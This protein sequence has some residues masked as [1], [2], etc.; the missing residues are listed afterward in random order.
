MC[1]ISY[2]V[3]KVRASKKQT[4]TNNNH[5]KCRTD[6]S[7]KPTKYKSAVSQSRNKKRLKRRK[8]KDFKDKTQHVTTEEVSKEKLNKQRTIK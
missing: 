4:I 5:S 7:E 1:I 6:S 3:C 8:D 2:D